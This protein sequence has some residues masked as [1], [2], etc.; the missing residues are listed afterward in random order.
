MK[1]DEVEF[2]KLLKILMAEPETE[3][4]SRWADVPDKTKQ[5]FK[6]WVREYKQQD[7]EYDDGSGWNRA[8]EIYHVQYITFLIDMK[9]AELEREKVERKG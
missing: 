3:Y 4:P 5:D 8:W 7:W 2:L 1:K 6:S 9:I